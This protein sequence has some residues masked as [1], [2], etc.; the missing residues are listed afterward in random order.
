MK[1]LLSADFHSDFSRLIQ[2]AK[3]VDLCICCGDIFDYHKLPT[4]TFKF[5]TPFFSIRGNKELWGS[6]K[7][8]KNLES[9]ENFFWLNENLKR[10]K[11]T[12]GLHFFGIDYLQ[13]PNSIPSNIDVLI[14]H[15]PAFGL[16][17]QCSDQFHT[18]MVPH[19]GN[20][21]LK[22]LIDEFIP[23][24]IVSGHVHYYQRQFNGKTH[25]I[26]LPPALVDPILVLKNEEGKITIEELVD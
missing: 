10:L 8:Q 18:K 15:Q 5:P 7:L 17:D 26:T 1:I 25:A 3:K 13:E 11:M 20:K 12:T 22:K 24:F 21:S 14:S 4:R 19:C 16:A 9:Y 6:G 23:K 2:I